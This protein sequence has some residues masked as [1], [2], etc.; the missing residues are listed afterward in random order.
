MARLLFLAL[1][2][3]CTGAL[4]QPANLAG[5]YTCHAYCPAGG[6]GGRT[7]IEQQG[8]TLVFINEGGNRARGAFLDASSVIANDWG[9]LR[10]TIH[11][12][13]QEL[14]WANRTVWRRTAAPVA[15]TGR[16]YTSLPRTSEQSHAQ[17]A[18]GVLDMLTIPNDKPVKVTSNIVLE[19]GRWYVLEATGVVSDWGD[20]KDGV[21]AVWCYAEWRCGK[22]GE[23]WQ[24]LRIDDKGMSELN[25]SG[26]TYNP[27]HVYRVRIQG[28]GKPIVVYAS[29][30]QNSWSDNSGAFTLRIYGDG[31]GA[32]A[33]TG[34]VDMLTIPN[35]RPVKITSNVML[36][37]GRWYVLEATGV[38]TD[39]SNVK[40]GVDAVWC[41]AE[42]RCG[43][44]GE[45]WQ[46]LR[47]DDKGMS[48]LNGSAIPYNAQH[49]YRVRIQGQGKPI[50][51]YASDAQNSWSD[52]AGSFTLRIYAEGGVAAGPETTGRSYTSQPR[53]QPASGNR[54][55]DAL[56]KGMQDAVK[57]MLK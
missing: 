57:G 14:H 12:G 48:D 5:D 8:T 27:Q 43:K 53:S 56:K 26:I 20:K 42:W 49:V 11:G 34:V 24:Q 18:T 33:A 32:V 22:T 54:L 41:Y 39:W 13:G 29:D 35:D 46:Q 21:D 23:A 45:H 44:A 28:Q 3:G 36:E 50:V 47:I 15:Q 25:G 38:I 52:N 31:A 51:A 4:A 19:R 55:Q 7:R 37:R 16:S 17:P 40:D 30:A 1:A 2:I 10:A 9:G 6:E